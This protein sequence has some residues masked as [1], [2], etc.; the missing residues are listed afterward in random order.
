MKAGSIRRGRWKICKTI[1]TLTTAFY[2][3]YV[4]REPHQAV[5]PFVREY[6][7]LVFSK[8]GQQIIASQVNG[9]IPLSAQE[10]AAE[11]AKLDSI[12]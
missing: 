12:D 10:A 7:R 4:R 5:D 6:F 11:L 9:Y 1:A 8:E 3:F 2:I